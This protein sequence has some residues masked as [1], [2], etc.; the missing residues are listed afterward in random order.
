MHVSIK[1]QS[2]ERKESSSRTNQD[3]LRWDYVP[4]DAAT[5]QNEKAFWCYILKHSSHK[6]SHM[7]WI[8]NY[9]RNGFIH[10]FRDGRVMLLWKKNMTSFWI[11]SF[12]HEKKSYYF[13]KYFKLKRL[14]HGRSISLQPK[15]SL[16]PGSN[17]L[18]WYLYL[19]VVKIPSLQKQ[20]D[21]VCNIHD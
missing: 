8:K 5:S 13:G 11:E 19:T 3:L 7:A 6:T 4:I 15:M 17:D 9:E 18:K 16:H 12:P 20:V 1:T 10:A 2:H 14:L 21:Q